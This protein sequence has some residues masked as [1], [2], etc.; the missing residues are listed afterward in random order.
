M[1]LTVR[2]LDR[3]EWPT[4]RELRLRAVDDAPDA[5]GGPGY[6]AEA[7]EADDAWRERL[8]TSDWLVV[9]ADDHA[10][11]EEADTESELNAPTT[12]GLLC[13]TPRM[14]DELAAGWIYSWWIDPRA[15][16]RGTVGL[17]VDAVDARC[18]QRG[19]TTVGLGT[20]PGND[21]ARRAFA[22]VGFVA[23]AQQ[24]GKLPPY[25]DFIPMTRQVA[26]HD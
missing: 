17:M 9:T 4:L 1:G 18:R 12:V 23:G 5:F 8:T 6:A 13:L 26:E 15:R 10:R 7:A 25:P 16:G 22:R 20:F 2:W 19:W 11:H 14:G 21:A 24:R 3:D